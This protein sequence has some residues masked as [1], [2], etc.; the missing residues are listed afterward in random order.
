[1]SIVNLTR[2]EQI[3]NELKAVPFIWSTLF[4]KTIRFSGMNDQFDSVVYYD[5]KSNPHKF[6]AF[7]ILSNKVVGVSTMDWDPLCAIFAEAMF[8]KIEV[9][10]EHIEKDPFDLKKLLL[11]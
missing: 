11:I 3:D 8:N 5:D 9:R 10:K 7:Y 2:T 6:A 4:G 1:M